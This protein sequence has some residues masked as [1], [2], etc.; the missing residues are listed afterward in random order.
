[1]IS[2]GASFGL[3]LLIWLFVA[4]ASIGLAIW[5]SIY[6]YR[7]GERTGNVTV[8]I[9]LIAIGLVAGLTLIPGICHFIGT[10]KAPKRT[11]DFGISGKETVKVRCPNCKA[12]ADEAAT[13]CPACGEKL[14]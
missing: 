14:S 5:G 12:L 6:A 9:V 11:M 3:M 1:M 7:H 2:H 13:F 10:T 8:S 4:V